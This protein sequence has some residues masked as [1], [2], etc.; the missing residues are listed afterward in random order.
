MD[1]QITVR[2]SDVVNAFIMVM[3]NDPDDTVDDVREYAEDAAN[4]FFE[5]LKEK[6]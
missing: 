5:L 2:K 4:Y 6:V 3:I 1:E